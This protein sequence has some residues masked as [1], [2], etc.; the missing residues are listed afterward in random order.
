MSPLTYLYETFNTYYFFWRWQDFF[1]IMFFASLFYYV[2]LWLKKDR[3]KNLLPYFYSYCAIA[4]TAY[5]LNFST[6]SFFLFLFWPVMVM[7]FMFMHQDILQRNII[8]LKNITA[9]KKKPADWIDTLLRISLQAMNKNNA[10]YCIIEHTDSIG[11]FIRTPLPITADLDQGL[12]ELLLHSSSY[13]PHK[14]IWTNTQGTLCGINATWRQ[15]SNT[16]TWDKT[17]WEQETLFYTAKTN[18]LAFYCTPAQHTFTIIIDNKIV[19]HLS[20]YD[21]RQ[22]IKK[23]F[24]FV[25]HETTKEYTI[26]KGVSDGAQEHQK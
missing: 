12:L 10:L 14:M 16:D 4:L 1:E 11:E 8:A 25:T 18:A 22:R 3:T 24:A 23:H 21:T 9:T 15:N 26:S 6:V 13:E 2:A 7:L 5:V 19:P 20:T 17:V